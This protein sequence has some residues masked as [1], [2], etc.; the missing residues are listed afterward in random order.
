MKITKAYLAKMV[1]KKHSYLSKTE[2]IETVEAL[3]RLAKDTLVGGTDLLLSGFGKFSIR[4][5]VSRQGRNP[6]TGKKL[7][8][9][10]RRVVTFKTSSKLRSKVNTERSA[11]TRRP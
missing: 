7:M 1:Y 11:T 4:N 9:D 3:L 2:A 5:K 10:A 6:K 8:L